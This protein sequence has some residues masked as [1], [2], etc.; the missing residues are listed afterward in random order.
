MVEL[1]LVKR[2]RNDLPN[3]E[4]SRAAKLLSRARKRSVASWPLCFDGR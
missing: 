2:T 4:L 1:L 3:R